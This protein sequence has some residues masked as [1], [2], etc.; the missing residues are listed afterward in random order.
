MVQRFC[1]KVQF[2]NFQYS[3]RF[4]DRNG[5][6]I[7][8]KRTKQSGKCR[9]GPEKFEQYKNWVD[10]V[11]DYVN[12]ENFATPH[13]FNVDETRSEP[14]EHTEVR[15]TCP[16]REGRVIYA[17][18]SDLRTTFNVISADGRVWLT[19]FIYCDENSVDPTKGGTIPTYYDK[20]CKNLIDECSIFS[21]E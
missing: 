19:L 15:L 21:V 5:T 3:R 7:K 2:L 6:Y 17:K 13:V 10:V 11:Q 12:K 14:R 1:E 16:E 18:P 9:F 4:I 20:V 8:P